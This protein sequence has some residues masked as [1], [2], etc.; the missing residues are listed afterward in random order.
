[1]TSSGGLAATGGRGN[2]GGATLTGSSASGGATA[3][4][5]AMGGPTGGRAT[6]GMAGAATG[7]ASNPGTG[8]S[9]SGALT[10]MLTV[11]VTTKAAGGRYQPDNVG[12]IWIADGNT[13]F[14]KSLFVW[15]SQRRRE[16]RTWVSATTAAGM[17]SSVVDAVTAAT[18]KSHGTRM[19]TWN[20][21]D[22]AKA[23][24]AD[25]PY[26]VCFELEDGSSAYQCVD[27]TKGRSAQ[28]L[29]PADNTSFTKRTIS[30]VP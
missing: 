10:G 1:M 22:T 2:T 20:G 3:T 28:T 19:A 4:G 14:V 15:G 17:A 25:G 11:T 9:G 21:T 6:G 30:Y 23:L 27:F 16:I 5:G 24:V 12:A 8:G 26:K 18:Y 13:K 7:G 29:M